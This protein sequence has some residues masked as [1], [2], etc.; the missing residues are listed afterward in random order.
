MLSLRIVG[1]CGDSVS[2]IPASSHNRSIDS[3][4]VEGSTRKT[5]TRLFIRALYQKGPGIRGQ[6][7]GVHRLLAGFELAHDYAAEARDPLLDLLVAGVAEVQPHRVV[8]AA[9]R[10]ERRAGDEGH[11]LLHR[12]LQQICRVHP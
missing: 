10:E 7:S 9:A 11:L 2:R 6:G 1:A 5:A 12:V 4:T 3:R 8:A